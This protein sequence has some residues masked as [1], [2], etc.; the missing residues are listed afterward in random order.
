MKKRSV[1]VAVL[2]IVVSGFLIFKLGND[3]NSSKK[4]ENNSHSQRS[5]SSQKSNS[6][7]INSSKESVKEGQ[8]ENSESIQKS[9]TTVGNIPATNGNIGTNNQNESDNSGSTNTQQTNK[10]SQQSISP[11]AEP[12]QKL[13]QPQ[14][15]WVKTFENSL[16]NQYGQV[17]Y[18]YVSI[19]NGDWEVWVQNYKNSE[20]PYVTVNENNGHYHG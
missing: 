4:L 15:S 20:E 2:L 8:D 5:D 14:G 10:E 19:G 11:K 12:N 13:N 16:Y 1:A 3:N 7:T 6:S 9:Q 17:P 18:K